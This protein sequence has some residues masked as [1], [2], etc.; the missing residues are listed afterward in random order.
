MTRA[1]QSRLFAL[2]QALTSQTAGVAVVAGQARAIYLAEGETAKVDD[3]TAIIERISRGE[4]Q[5]AM[6]SAD[7]DGFSF[8]TLPMLIETQRKIGELLADIA[9]PTSTR[10]DD[11][12]PIYLGVESAKGSI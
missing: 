10:P 6:D 9:T 1:E 4:F 7:L 12:R 8:V 3:M 11:T 5:R 2:I